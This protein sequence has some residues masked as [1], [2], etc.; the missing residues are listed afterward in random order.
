MIQ[1]RGGEGD[2]VWGRC[3]DDTPMC[4]ACVMRMMIP[5]RVVQSNYQRRGGHNVALLERE[6]LFNTALALHHGLD[7]L[8]SVP[9]LTQKH[10]DSGETGTGTYME[11]AVTPVTGPGWIQCTSRCR[12]SVPTEGSGCRLYSS[13]ATREHTHT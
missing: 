10:W 6:Q 13:H 7:T 2:P 5:E 4:H 1:S 11:V 12:S 3:E 8:G 9:P